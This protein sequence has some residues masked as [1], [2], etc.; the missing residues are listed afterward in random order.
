MDEIE[1]ME[2][3]SLELNG[4]ERIFYAYVLLES[5][6]DILELALRYN[7]ITE[8]EKKYCSNVR[9]IPQEEVEKRNKELYKKW[10]EEHKNDAYLSG[11]IPPTIGEVLLT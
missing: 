8:D 5:E 7:F 9:R 11:K 10:Y 2:Y 6:E 1:E 4:M 3:Y